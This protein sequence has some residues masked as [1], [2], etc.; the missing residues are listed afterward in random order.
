MTTNQKA[1][2]GNPSSVTLS[3]LRDTPKVA[4]PIEAKLLEGRSMTNSV[5]AENDG[6]TVKL[7]GFVNKK[8]VLGENLK[9]V[10]L[11]D[12]TG[13]VQVVF[14]RGITPDDVLDKINGIQAQSAVVIE[15][16]IRKTDK[17]QSGVEISGSSLELLTLAGENLPIPISNDIEKG[18]GPQINLRQDWRFIDLRSNRNKLIF[19]VTSDFERFAREYFWDNKLIEIHTPK[20]IG[21]AS[22]S[23]SEL[24]AVKEYFGKNAY[25]AQSPQFYKQMAITAGFEPGIFEIGPVFRAEKS[26][27]HRHATEFTSVDVELAF[28]RSYQDIM[29]FEQQMI[30]KA[31]TGISEKYG[32]DIKRQF[33]VDLTVPKTPFPQI[34]MADAHIIVD[35]M[36]VKTDKTSDLSNEGELAI[37]R[38]AKEKYGSEFVFVIEFPAK[39]RPFY[40]MRPAE[41]PILTYSFDLLFKGLE[42]TTGAQ[43]EH[44]VET[45]TK[46]ALEKG[47][48]EESI[49]FYLDF[50]R[51]GAPP[52]GGYG[53]GLARM[54]MSM[55]GLE[56]IRESTF[57]HRDPT[58][59][60]P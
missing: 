14:E 45:L 15:G 13:Q 36:G 35:S 32:S 31:M 50:F 33:G 48:D 60:Y 52:H 4:D 10:L 38:Y 56:N 17:T 20:L 47:L 42:I 26:N 34:T 25:L 28:I 8:R 54:T 3:L 39:A 1:K 37:G 24:F 2:A 19:G 27:T 55:L 6:K 40:H 51:Y 43:R 44:R 7:A 41:N 18:K 58:R 16:T 23:G 29:Q 12:F 53:F 5:I 21:T 30:V 9:F 22:E 46:Q 57:L 59:L 49:G 11:G